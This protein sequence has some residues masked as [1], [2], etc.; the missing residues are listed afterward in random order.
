MDRLEAMSM[1]LAVAEAGSLAAAA[2][3][4]NTP[5]A[6]ASRKITELETHLRA[7]LFDR[8]ARSL[9]LTDAGLS[10]VAALKRILADLSEAERAASGEFTAP[11]GELV[12]TAPVALG[13]THLMP[14]LAEFLRAYPDITV[15]LILGDR[16][17]SLSEDRID[18]ALRVGAL[19][20]SR[21]IALRLGSTCRVVCASPAYLASRG[22]PRA[23]DDLAGHECIV[24][25]GQQVPD[26]WA[27]VRDKT[28]IAIAV[29]PRLVVSTVEAACDAARAGIGLT[30]AL[31][32]H[33]A[34]SVEAGTLAT[35]LDEYRPVPLPIHLVYTAGPFLPIKLRTFLDFVSPH[36]KARLAG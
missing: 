6:T 36:L 30:Q 34:A 23:P 26:L 10:Y 22:T 5:V 9:M 11:T 29:R 16:I 33:V 17:L 12:V 15:R 19:P 4:L 14:I 7:K 20:D 35:V 8:S 3:R 31:S 1:V 28:D 21:M 24:Y 32:Y 18:V 13:R 25:D 2:R 27:F